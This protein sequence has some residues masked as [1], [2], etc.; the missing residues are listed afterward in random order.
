MSE[1]TSSRISSRIMVRKDGTTKK[2]GSSVRLDVA[3]LEDPLWAFKWAVPKVANYDVGDE[4]TLTYDDK[5]DDKPFLIIKDVL[6]GTPS[7]S[8]KSTKKSS[9]SSAARSG[10]G[11]DS[12]NTMM[13]FSYLKDLHEQHLKAGTKDPIKAAIKAGSSLYEGAKNI[14][15]P[16]QTPP[17]NAKKANDVQEGRIRTMVNTIGADSE[18]DSWKKFVKTRYGAPLSHENANHLIKMLQDTIDGKMAVKW[19]PDEE[20]MFYDPNAK[21]ETVNS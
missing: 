21:P 15:N 18:S 20:I 11:D 6:S 19:T 17:E 3:D 7:G 12:R 13:V 14:V 8:G 16:P 5:G 9:G 2:G 10:G 4:I 1:Q